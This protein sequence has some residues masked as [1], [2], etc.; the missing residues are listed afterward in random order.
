MRCPTGNI[1]FSMFG[2]VLKG[3]DFFVKCQLTVSQK[4]LFRRKKILT[5]SY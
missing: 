1:I 4:D 3:F 2:L 5:I